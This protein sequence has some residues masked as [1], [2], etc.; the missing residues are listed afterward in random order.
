M[1]T[2]LRAGRLGLLLTL[3]L[4]CL[5]VTAAAQII[6]IKTV[7]VASG[8]QFLIIPAQNLG[9]G[10]VSIALND[11]LIDPFV[12]PAKGRMTRGAK[13]FGGSAFY[14]ISGDNGSGR[15]LPMAVLVGSEK[16]FGGG[17][18]AIQQLVP[19]SPTFQWPWFGFG[20][21]DPPLQSPFRGQLPMNRYGFGLLGTKLPGGRVAIA[22][23]ISA[24]DLEA[25]DGVELLYARS[26]HIKQYGR[27]VGYRLGLSGDLS[28]ERT[29]EVLLLHT[30]I[31]MT[32]DVTYPGPAGQWLSDDILPPIPVETH[33]ARNFDRSNTTGL[34]LGYVQPM[35]ESGWRIGGILTG[36]WK[37]HPKIPEYELPHMTP[38]PRDPGNS[39][40]YNF[41]LGLSKLDDSSVFGIDFVYEP[42][43]T[44]T[45]GEAAEAI[46]TAG[47]FIIPPGGKTVENDFRFSNVVLRIGAAWEYKTSGLQL[48]LQVR[49]VNYRLHQLN[50]IER[51]NRDQV[52]HW[53]EWTPS[54]GA[55]L[56]FPEF[57]LRYVGRLQLGTGRPGAAS[58]WIAGPRSGQM[59]DSLL[60]GD[61]L[62][63]P[64]G[65]L[66]LQDAEII[67]HQFYLVVPLRF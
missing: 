67:T 34:H 52:E 36:N 50:N 26:L 63:A 24:A 44:E 45:W 4:L 40:A 33:V 21:I 7:P 29:F 57:Q 43:W 16:W 60:L 13:L 17:A 6:S 56:K 41:G 2:L 9:M 5:P 53:M 49:S 59:G 37:S 15:T 51:F 31:N 48:G 38:I 11:P 19:A 32:H 46:E 35:K 47:G 1:N 65:S 22:A 55:K 64:T 3:A 54:W 62:V 66:V 25:I 14:S 12:N 23:S 61:F 39:W 58:P 8:D 42:V 28:G 20:P 18:V 30:R 10:G 27:T